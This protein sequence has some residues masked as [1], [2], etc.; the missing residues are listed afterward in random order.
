MKNAGFDFAEREVYHR[1]FLDF[2]HV[3]ILYLAR[4]IHNTKYRLSYDITEEE[5]NALKRLECKVFFQN[6]IKINKSIELMKEDLPQTIKYY[7][8]RSG[9]EQSDIEESHKMYLS[10]LSNFIVLGSEKMFRYKSRFAPSEVNKLAQKEKMETNSPQSN[11]SLYSLYEVFDN[12]AIRME[13][14]FIFNEN[15][16][17]IYFS[18]DQKTVIKVLKS[19]K[20][21]AKDKENL[22]N[23]FKVAKLISHPAFRRSIKRTMIEN[24]EV[25]ILQWCPGFPINQL[26]NVTI[27]DFLLIAREIV[28][29]LLTMHIK[30]IMHMN[31][32]SEHIIFD[33]ESKNVKIIGCGSSTSFISKAKYISN[34]ELLENDLRYIS[35]E[36]TGRINR[37]IDHRSDFYSLG[38][39]FYRLLTGKHPFESEN[40]WELLHLHL[41][42]DPLPVHTMNSNVPVLLSTMV[43]KLMAK[44]ADDRYQCTKVSIMKFLL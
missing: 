32:T 28:S 30:Q 5:K 37:V 38:I 21:L 11:H 31:L 18:T 22:D 19:S 27:N 10:F 24:R 40:A 9:F 23:E 2:M 44:N 36:Q 25:L 4:N 35:P 1:S 6:E 12:I 15:K 39:I 3:A 26:E 42:K 7:M 29:S 17:F 13:R 41:C 14:D 16:H 43:S 34:Q 8:L 20:S 33:P